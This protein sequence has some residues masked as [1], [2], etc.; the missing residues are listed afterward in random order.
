MS[1][2]LSCI[3]QL[4]H[5]LPTGTMRLKP[6]RPI[7]DPM[8]NVFITGSADGL[9]YA[10]AQALLTAGHQVVVHARE[11][12]RLVAVQ[13]LLDQGATAVI[14]DLSDLKQTVDVA[15]QVNR[16]GQMDAV[17]HNA[18]V[19]SG[20]QV[21]PVNVIAPYVLTALITKPSRLV[22]LSSGMHFSGR[23]RLNG[24][25]ATDRHAAGSYSDSKLFVTTLMAAVARLW[26][27]VI[28][29]AVDPGWVATKMGGPNAPDDLRLGHVT[30]AWLAT[31]Q[32][33]EAQVSGGYWHHQRRVEPH[34]AVKDVAF[35]NELLETLEHVTGIGLSTS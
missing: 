7:E 1:R 16:I 18:G 19:Y 8:S 6:S 33:A 26:P 14:G 17:I 32:D 15:E 3:S 10:A 9:G 25:A 2:P 13:K 20:P 11:R 31:S 23:P 4:V 12:Q 34:V 30:Q 5:R 28:S 27:D 24:F 22:Y 35:Q 21:I 29:S